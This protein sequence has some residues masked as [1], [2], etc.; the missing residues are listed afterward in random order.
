MPGMLAGAAAVFLH[1]MCGLPEFLFSVATANRV[2]PARF[3]PGLMSNTVPVRS[4]IPLTATFADVIEALSAEMREVSAHAR[5][6]GSD[7][8][9][10]AG[11]SGSIEGPFGPVLNIIPWTEVQYFGDAPAHAGDIRFGT[12][13]ELMITVMDDAG[14]AGGLRI[15]VDA[16]A[17]RYGEDDVRAFA[18]RLILLWRLLIADPYAPVGLVDMMDED[19]RHRVLEEW[20]GAARPLLAGTVP[21]AL[22]GQAARTPHA[23]AVVGG[24]ETLTYAELRTRARRLA[25]R[26]TARGVGPEDLVALAV[27]RS[28]DML[29]AMLAI[30]EAGAAY[31][32]IDVAYPRERIEFLL[33]DAAPAAVVASP[34]AA[35]RLPSTGVPVIDPAADDPADEPSGA[36]LPAPS[37][38]GLAY[39]MYTSGST[40]APKGV[41]VTH[42]DVVG[43]ASDPRFAGPH[44]TLAQSPQTFDASTFEIWVPLLTGGCV[45]VAPAGERLDA[46][47]LRDLIAK[48][49]LT[50]V[51]VT[52][53]LFSV[54]A[55]Q[56]PGCFTGL[57]QV[58]AGGDVLVGAA[59][60][61]VQRAC[62]GLLVVNGYGPTEATTFAASHPVPGLTDDSAVVPI[63]TPMA[64]MRAYVLDRGLAPVPAGVIGELYIG[65]LGVARGYLG[66]PG[67]TASR[68]VADPFGSGG[69]LYRTGD[70]VRWNARGELVF[71]GRADDQLKVRGFRIEPGEVEA[72][73]A[74]HPMVAQAAVA[75][76]GDGADKQLAGYVAL[77]REAAPGADPADDPVPELRRFAADRLPE[78]M[79]PSVFTVLD[80]LPLTAN[81]KLDRR[82]LPA[83]VVRSTEPRSA[84]S[85]EE[86]LLAEAFAEVLGVDRVGVDEDFFLLGGHSLLAMRVAGRIR[87]VLGVDVSVRTVFEAPT[88][89]RLARRLRTA[90]R[91]TPRPLPAVRPE[92]LPLSYAQRRLWFLF[93]FEGP[94]LTYNIPVVFKLRGRVDAAVMSAA[95]RDVAGRH[96]SLRTVVGED[97]NG[98]AFQRILPV[99]GLPLD[100]PERR[101]D[102]AAVRDAVIELVSH[103]FD[104]AS[105][106]PLRAGLVRGAPD[107]CVLVLLM[108]HIAGDGASMAPLVRDL[109][110]AYAARSAGREP[111]WEPLPVQYADYTLWQ[112]DLLGDE[113]DPGS[114]LS[115]QLEYWRGELAGVPQPLPL[116]ADRPRPATRDHR[117]GTV[118][119]AIGADLA[120]RVRRLARDRRATVPMVFQAALAVLLARH[121]AGGDV[122]IGS[123][124]EGRTDDALTDLVGFFVNTWVLRVR[125]SGDPSFEDVLEETRTKALAAYDNQD[126][127]FERLVELLNPERSAAYHP[128]FQVMFAWQ[129]T[130]WPDLDSPDLHW[131]PAFPTNVTVKFDLSLTLAEEPDGRAIRGAFEYALDLFDRATVERM[132]DRY[133]RVLDQVTADAGRPVRDLDVPDR[134]ELDLVVDRWN[135]TAAEV[136]AAT[137]PEL[138]EAAAA[139]D[140]A[141]IALA[142]GGES[143]TYGELGTRAEALAAE[144][145]ARGA[146]PGRVVAVALPR[147]MDL[148]VALLAVLKAGGAYLPIEPEYPSE[149]IR[150]IL[151]DARPVLIVTDTPTAAALP[152]AAVPTLLLDETAR[153]PPEPA[154]MRRPRPDD[155]AYVIYTSGST[156][157]PKGVEVTHRNVTSL[158]TG[159]RDWA[160]FGPADVWAWCHSHAFDFSVWEIWGALATGGRVVVVPWDVVRSPADLW[161]LLTASGVTVLNQTPSAFYQLAENR[162][163]TR[164][165]LRMVVFGGEALDPSRLSGWY[166]GRGDDGPALVNMFGITETTVHVTRRALTAADAEDPAASPIGR[167][168]ANVRTYVL[169]ERLRPAPIGVPGELYVGGSGV[170][171]GYVGRAGLSAARFVADPFGSGG[172]LYR[173]G[174]LARWTSAGELEFLGRADDQV[175]VRGFRIEPGEIEA[176]LLAHPGVAQ[177]AVIA[178]DGDGG[179]ARLVGYVV[180]DAAAVSDAVT[181][182]SGGVVEFGD[183]VTVD[184]VVVGDL[185][186]DLRRFAASR[187]P[188]YMVPAAI[189]PLERL[190]LTANGKLDRA[191]LPAPVFATGAYRAPATAAEEAL[192]RILADVLG[193]ERVGADDDFFAVGGDS[194]R[195]I[196]VVTRARAEGLELSPRD[197]FDHRTVAR[198]C[199]A[200]EANARA[201][202]R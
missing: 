153:R 127:P 170:A 51:W 185:A 193:L 33:A 103:R 156:G 49:E 158:L 31:L 183:A 14:P 3:S 180:P 73:L 1:R 9:S 131:S 182:S 89:E 53:G 41:L 147:S 128:F 168:L 130:L 36:S 55:E 123:P 78:F 143:L 63:G 187:L 5:C 98:V 196:Q 28:I 60:R 11:L 35:G 90:A 159:A 38:G 92:R 132:A 161:R 124:I 26:L 2:G 110:L 188:E 42:A 40:G 64:N 162:P 121:G 181:G 72:V 198:L 45:A 186:A 150:Y 67:L 114:L 52:A 179:G 59:V 66:R 178:R 133:A 27:P 30:L 118:E 105:E 99:D 18:D 100:V 172:R 22:R 108:H 157:A 69:R 135:D 94:S 74:S 77:D 12:V 44:R 117:G 7:I 134:D 191:N 138:V 62:P 111:G 80:A 88:V 6:Q 126:A 154:A 194:I 146:G 152:E 189:V 39:V 19:E 140:P 149:R 145:S 163:E 177:A 129:N 190:P 122:A 197:I 34:E 199:G 136:V 57:R 15:C 166:A 102:P 10:A 101:V 174:D 104:L 169:D 84:A 13:N 71:A 148:V 201:G 164:S 70:L 97:E 4:A 29:V 106:I 119:F 173:S 56:D 184:G 91:G 37:P 86:E 200:A 107:E 109:S 43:L 25:H 171:R 87:E 139:Q 68:F 32:P 83:P 192:A 95:L 195:S 23:P 65:G 81:G 16:N 82:A 141:A 155:L 48:H 112:R 75:A 47:L 93:R 46:G 202:A 144:L 160:A 76:H 24:D 142:S 8:R 116:P 175:K 151:D 137:V 167:P 61:R 54:L 125:L 113:S 79:V 20:N 17:S 85:A 58:W 50:A 176:V 120:D 21:E 115:R 165:A 96:E